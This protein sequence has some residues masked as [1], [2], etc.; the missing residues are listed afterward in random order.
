MIRISHTFPSGPGWWQINDFTLRVAEFLPV[1]SLGSLAG[2]CRQV[3]SALTWPCL[4]LTLIGR[5]FTPLE[6]AFNV[7][8]GK[9][10]FK[11]YKA[12]YAEQRAREERE[13]WYM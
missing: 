1:G 9:K 7:T 13:L 5:D 2:A 8:D 6:K 10:Y 4:W 3:W 12:R 11:I